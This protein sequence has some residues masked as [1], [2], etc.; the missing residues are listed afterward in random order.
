FYAGNP[1]AGG[2]LLSD[3]NGQSTVTI[4][5]SYLARERTPI[6]FQ[7]KVPQGISPAPRI[8]VV[9]DPNNK[10]TEVHDDNNVGFHLLGAGS[11]NSVEEA[12][13]ASPLQLKL[14]PNPATEQAQ[15]EMMLPHAGQLSVQLFDMQG[16]L[17][18][19]AYDQRLHK[20]NFILPI[21]IADLPSGYYM[22]KVSLDQKQE[23]LKLVKTN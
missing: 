13:T 17:L 7:W 19:T 21:D 4:A 3:I 10:I 22:V 16:R 5:D 15:V 8:Y 6:S 9:I 23:V 1:D 18:K 14:S 12:V 11:I 20:G 2:V